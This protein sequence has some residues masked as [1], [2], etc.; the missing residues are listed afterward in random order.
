MLVAALCQTHCRGVLFVQPLL[1]HGHWRGYVPAQAT[2][3]A[4]G[5]MVSNFFA[6]VTGAKTIDQ[7]LKDMQATANNAIAQYK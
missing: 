1:D 5:G 7:A 4:N 3:A 6:A 2:D